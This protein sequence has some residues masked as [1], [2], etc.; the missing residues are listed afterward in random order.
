[1]KSVDHS[2]PVILL[3]HQPVNLE[4][5]ERNKVDLQL[6]GHTHNGQFWPLNY[7]TQAYMKSAMATGKRDILR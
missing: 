5:A 7:F 6:S 4:E 3:D 2:R 1:M